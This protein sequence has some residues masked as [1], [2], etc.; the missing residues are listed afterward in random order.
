MKL[1]Q[2]GLKQEVMIK[3]KL[4]VVDN[5][6]MNS[7]PSTL[8]TPAQERRNV[9]LAPSSGSRTSVSHPLLA[10]EN[11][12]SCA[13][14][15]R[16]PISTSEDLIC[17]ICLSPMAPQKAITNNSD[18]DDEEYDQMLLVETSCKVPFTFLSII[19]MSN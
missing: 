16:D 1:R 18:F 10:S 17:S 2:L 5:E 8:V 4:E 11:A 12:V 15:G 6:Q 14:T 19:S 9:P 3:D 7:T 13:C